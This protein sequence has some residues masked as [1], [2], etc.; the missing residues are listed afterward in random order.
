[1]SPWRIFGRNWR[2]LK[3][4]RLLISTRN[5]HEQIFNL[6]IFFRL[7]F[8]GEFEHF[9]R[10]GGALIMQFFPWNC[11]T[12]RV[13][14][15]FMCIWYMQNFLNGCVCVCVKARMLW[16]SGIEW[17]EYSNAFPFNPPPCTREKQLEEKNPF[18]EKRN[19]KW[20]D[21]YRNN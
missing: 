13:L 6:R 3:T 19:D 17:Y 11:R 1:M 18:Q 16:H 15:E 2:N 12:F 9:W 20:K 21:V 5:I 10:L 7:H 4:S 14:C 8:G